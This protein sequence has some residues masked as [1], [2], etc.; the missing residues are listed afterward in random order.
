MKYVNE[1]EKMLLEQIN[2]AELMKYNSQIAEWTRIT[3]LEEER[4]SLNYIRD[5]LDSFG[6]ETAMPEYMGYISYPVKSYVTIE[7]PIERAFSAISCCFTPSTFI[8]GI[9]AEAAD[10]SETNYQE[11][12]VLIDGLADVSK[13]KKAERAGAIGVIFV[14]DANIHNGP[15]SDIWGNPTVKCL[16]TLA[17]IPALS[18]TKPAGTEIRELLKNGHVNIRLEST[19]VNEWR[20]CPLLIADLKI[21]KSNKFI[22]YSGHIDSWDYGAMDNGSANATMIECAKIIAAKKNELKR[23]I[24]IAFWT[25]HSQGKYAGSAWYADNHF[26]ELEENCVAHVNIDSV[27]G[28]NSVVIEEPPVMAQAWDLA[29]DVIEEQTGTKFKGKRMARNSD[30]S[31]F[32]IGVTSIFGTFSEQDINNIGDS[33]SFRY[34]ANNRAGG[35]GWWWH[36]E[37][38]TIDKI[39]PELL[40]RDCNIYLIILWRLLTTPVL[41]FRIAKAIAEMQST[42]NA[43]QAKLQGHF[44]FTPLLNRLVA[45]YDEAEKFDEKCLMS[46]DD[47]LEC[48]QLVEKQLKICRAIVR[49]AYHESDYYSFDQCGPLYPLPNLECGEK[50]ATSIEGSSRYYLYKTQLQKGYNR[51]MGYCKEIQTLLG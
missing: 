1:T 11:K 38:D 12:I 37:H 35:L 34:G 47:N 39:D 8:G 29:K 32:G 4:D 31:L 15:A 45:I 33:L 2:C 24:R 14:H 6:F 23:G 28:L 18:I 26:E 41:P 48:E 19:V 7:S 43:L 22:L 40:I 5:I 20:S 36:T 3:S 46:N 17:A 30:Q 21:D 44:D 49:I 9:V 42:V 50:L 51:V 13:I 16:D 10:V 27:G 25:G